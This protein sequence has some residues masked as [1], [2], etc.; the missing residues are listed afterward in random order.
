MLSG[1]AFDGSDRGSRLRMF[2]Y[3]RFKLYTIVPIV[4]VELNSIQT[5]EVVAIVRVFC[6]RPGSVSIKLARS[7][8]HYLKELGRLG[9]QAETAGL[10]GRSVMQ[11]AP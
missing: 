8:E 1:V 9:H 3:D 7:P 5:I 10:L 6:D 2:P 11:K 4:R